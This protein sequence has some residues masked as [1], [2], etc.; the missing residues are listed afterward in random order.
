[1]REIRINN[2]SL[3][4]SEFNE[5]VEILKMEPNP[6]F[7]K[8]DEFKKEG[9]RYVKMLDGMPVY[10]SVSC[11][12]RP[13]SGYVIAWFDKNEDDGVPPDLVFCMNRPLELSS[14][15]FKDFMDVVRFGYDEFKNRKKEED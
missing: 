4:Y 10:Y 1:M 5:R 13:E 11:F 12:E 3:K 6:L 14:E 9:D 15:E 8:E 2:I 7:G